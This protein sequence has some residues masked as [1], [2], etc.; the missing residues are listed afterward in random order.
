M[1]CVVSCGG[2]SFPQTDTEDDH[3]IFRKEAEA[4]VKSLMKGKSAGVDNIPAELV[5][6][7]GED[8]VPLSQQSATRSGRQ[9]NGQPCGPS[10]GSSHFPPPKGNLKQCQSYQSISL[11]SHLSKVVLK[12]ILNRLKLQ[13]EKIIAKEQP[14]FR[15]GRS[16]TEQTFNLRVLCEKHL[17][18]QQDLYHVFIDFKKAFNRVWHAALWATMKKCNISANLIRVINNLCDKA[19]SAVLFNS[20]VGD[21]FRTT[22]GVR[23]GC[24]LSPTLFNIFLERIMTDALE[25]HEGTISI[26]YRAITNLRFADATMA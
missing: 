24:L 3:P 13:E 11:I 17:Q 5:Q 4:A 20:S 19:T 12:I 21:W 25:D 8:V 26:G 6:A 18:H 14:R 1:R 16:T 22:V 2:T 9:E 23:Q 10:A 15:S 7:G